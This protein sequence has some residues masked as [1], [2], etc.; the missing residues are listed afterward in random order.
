ML[1]VTDIKVIEVDQSRWYI[2][3]MR[4]PVIRPYRDDD[5]YEPVEVTREMIE[6]KVFKSVDGREICIGM[7]KQVQDAIGLP[8]EVFDNLMSIIRDQHTQIN[9]LAT[10]KKLN[11]KLCRKIS[12]GISEVK[13]KINLAIE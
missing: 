12:T 3:R 9:Q 2:D 6:G 7:S 5:G 11:A 4:G 1:V 10:G 8:L 13:R